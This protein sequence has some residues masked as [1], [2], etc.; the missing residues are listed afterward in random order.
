MDY[1]KLSLDE[2][3]PNPKNPRK[4]SKKHHRQLADSIRATTYF[5]PLAVDEDNMMARPF[6]F[7]KPMERS[8]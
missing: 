4:H 1:P 3:R 5:S 8:A 6:Y 2:L 7:Y